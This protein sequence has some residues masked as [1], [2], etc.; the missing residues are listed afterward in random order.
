MANVRH[1]AIFC[2]NRS[3]RSGDMADYQFS[4]WLPY[5]ILDLQKL[6]FLT[7][8]VQKF[9]CNRRSNFD[10]IQFLIFCA[11]SLKMPIHAP[12]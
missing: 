4:I 1:H 7:A 8:K 9:G 6:E 2:G 12:K 10:S 11:L 3:N 5:A